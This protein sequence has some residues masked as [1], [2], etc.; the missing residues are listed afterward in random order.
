MIG[1]K[2]QIYNFPREI[3]RGLDLFISIL[4]KNDEQ[5]K[6]YLNVLHFNNLC[7][8]NTLHKTL[9]IGITGRKQANFHNRFLLLT[10]R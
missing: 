4:K 8:I 9:T 6:Y 7:S 5:L 10:N 3:L 1:M 2:L